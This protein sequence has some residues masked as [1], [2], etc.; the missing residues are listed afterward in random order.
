MSNH[1]HLALETPNGDLCAG[2]Q[3]LQTTFSN[4]Y[5]RFRRESGHVFQG[6]YKALPVEPGEHLGQLINYIDLNPARA[7]IKSLDQ[8]E[9][10]PYGS[11]RYLFSPMARPPWLRMESC[12]LLSGG[13]SDDPAGWENY[14]ALLSEQLRED[15]T[16][17]PAS[18]VKLSRGWALGSEE[19]KARLV[20]EYGLTEQARAWETTGAKEVARIRWQKELDRL[21]ARL[22]KRREDAAAGRKSAP[23]KIAIAAQ[24]KKTTSASNGWLAAVLQMGT[25]TMVSQTMQLVRK[26]PERFADDLAR[27]TKE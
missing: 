5:N 3:W 11:F 15:R 12:L 18:E 16:N 17:S 22:G 13:L 24:L 8:L 25:P 1:F 10:Y 4:R 19:F 23:W 20:T 14:R 21:L 2:M 26:M 9:S 7:G 6:R 27:L